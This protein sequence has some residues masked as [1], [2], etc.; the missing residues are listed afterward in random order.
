MDAPFFRD[1]R[2]IM[3]DLGEYWSQKAHVV[4]GD[5][6]GKQLR[7]DGFQ[8]AQERYGGYNLKSFPR[9]CSK[10]CP[11][12]AYKPILREVEKILQEAGLDEEEMRRGAAGGPV[13]A[14]AAGTSRNRR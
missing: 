12:A 7:R 3:F 10:R 4:G 2:L 6:R 1:L 8:F 9:Q 13:S 14:G 5:N 11:L